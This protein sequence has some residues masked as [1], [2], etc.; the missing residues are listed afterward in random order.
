MFVFRHLERLH[1]DKREAS[2]AGGY[3]RRLIPGDPWEL[4]GVRE[5]QGAG[6]YFQ[7]KLINL[8]GRTDSS[9]RW[10]GGVC[11]HKPTTPIMIAHTYTHTDTYTHTNRR[12]TARQNR[13]QTWVFFNV[14]SICEKT[15]VCI[16]SFYIPP[17]PQKTAIF[18]QNNTVLN[19]RICLS[20]RQGFIIHV[21]FWMKPIN[22]KH[23]SGVK[24]VQ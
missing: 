14:L 11:F 1:D 6:L 24:D 22:I 17:H 8:S 9:V 7:D 21:K 2:S 18:F 4:R 15:R 19:F 10:H 5:V 12:R 16:F 3:S 20:L 23:R 13:A